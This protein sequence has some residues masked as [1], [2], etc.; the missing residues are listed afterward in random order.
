MYLWLEIFIDWCLATRASNLRS[1]FIC[2]THNFAFACIGMYR[3]SRFERTKRKRERERE[4]RGKK[5]G[6]NSGIG[7]T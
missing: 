7:A 6:K 1:L 3:C 4:N 2:V 5:V